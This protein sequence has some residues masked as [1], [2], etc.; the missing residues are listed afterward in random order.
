MNTNLTKSNLDGRFC[1]QKSGGSEVYKLILPIDG[2]GS[3]IVAVLN[4]H[5]APGP[6]THCKNYIYI[7]YPV[8]N[9]FI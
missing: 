1:L 4:P 7:G 8:Y 9:T 3:G 6:C 2:V 5:T